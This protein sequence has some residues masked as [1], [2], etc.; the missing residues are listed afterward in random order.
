MADKE[1]IA[2][3]RVVGDTGEKEIL[4]MHSHMK[5]SH[6]SNWQD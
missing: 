1:W 5:I 3:G 4:V 2:I 6:Q